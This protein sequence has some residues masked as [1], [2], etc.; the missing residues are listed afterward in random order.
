MIFIG[1]NHEKK[2][3]KVFA[4]MVQDAIM[5]LI[6]EFFSSGWKTVRVFESSDRKHAIVIAPGMRPFIVE[7]AIK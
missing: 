3:Q 7:P 2:S 1:R 5:Q 4:N 6:P